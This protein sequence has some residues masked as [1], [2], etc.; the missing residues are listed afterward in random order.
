MSGAIPL[1]PVCLYGVY[2]DDF[3]LLCVLIY[4]YINKKPSYIIY[5][6]VLYMGIIYDGEK[7]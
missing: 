3:C 6:I 7:C 4:I 1:L 2:R 5:Y